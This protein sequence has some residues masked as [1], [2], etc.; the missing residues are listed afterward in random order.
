[1]LLPG[2]SSEQLFLGDTFKNTGIGVQVV[3]TG[4]YKGAVE[5]FT[6]NKFS[7]EN[8][9]QV[10]NLLDRRWIHYLQSVATARSMKWQ[11]LNSTLS[12]KFLWKSKDAKK[13]GLVDRIDDLGGVIERLIELGA[14]EE[15]EN[16]FVQLDFGTY[17]ERLR[18]NPLDEV[19]DDDPKIAI[20]YVEGAIVD[21]WGDNGASVGGDEI[22][23][24]I[25][26]IRKKPDSYKAIVL[27][28]NSPGGSVSGSEAILFELIRARKQVF[29]LCFTGPL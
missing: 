9:I 18:P 17:L 3:R 21:G 28:I 20:I 15:K 1:M 12:Q 13:A 24:R 26:K 19:N 14:E 16:T 22:A 8:R 5:P 25:R 7:T 23:R 11:D 27:R 29:R 4:R 6:N 10:Q 2:L